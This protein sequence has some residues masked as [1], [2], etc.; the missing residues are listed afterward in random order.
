[1][2]F[3]IAL[4]VVAALLLLR[5]TTD[6]SWN[7]HYTGDWGAESD[8]LEAARSF[9]EHGFAQTGFLPTFRS[10][11][12]THYPPGPYLIN[13]VPY[14]LF[15]GSELAARLASIAITLVGLAFAWRSIRL[16]LELLDAP[17]TPL[18]EWGIVALVT[19]V[20]AVL[21]FGD[22]MSL[23]PMTE[24]LQWASL[25]WVLRYAFRDA[26]LWIGALLA[27]LHVWISFEWIVGMMLVL[28]YCLAITRGSPRERPR[29]WLMVFG[30]GFAL[31]VA[32]RV[33]QNAWALGGLG[34]AVADLA[35]AAGTR[36]GIGAASGYSG[37]RH[38]GKFV[39]ALPWFA[40]VPAL[41]L[42]AAGARAVW[43]RARNQQHLVAILALWGIGSLSWQLL[44]RQHALVHAFTYLHFANFVILV[45]ALAAVVLH[46][47]LPGLVTLCLL[48]QWLWM[49]SLIHSEIV[50]PFVEDSTRAVAAHVCA[51]DRE[52]L[53]RVFGES[54]SVM[55]RRIEASLEAS[56]PAPECD[57]RSR[58]GR[59]VLAFYG[60]FVKSSVSRGA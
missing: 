52:D 31:P 53:A 45:A 41:L 58:L 51:R 16:L 32:L 29:E 39:A 8:F 47:R 34:A 2:P 37:V 50:R 23:Q 48:A 26:P 57:A 24:A 4:A 13:G 54:R 5:A 15:G 3:R 9:E 44:M 22:T 17:T 20:P 7:T 38:A 49:G 36:A 30:L 43:L 35:G 10:R 14:V 55:V 27:F 56:P 21:C 46:E 1:M 25:Y 18:L 59:G 19:G 11:V 12:Y 40:G 28:G 60:S 6:H 33:A 42:A